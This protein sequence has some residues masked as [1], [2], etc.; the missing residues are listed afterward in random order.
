MGCDIHA[1]TEIKVNGKWLH[2][3][4]PRIQRD[5]RLFDKMAKVRHYTENNITP[6]S[7]PR[8]LPKGLSATTKLCAVHMGEDGHSH[9]WL[10]GKELAEVCRWW[11]ELKRQENESG[12]YSLEHQHIGYLFGNGWDLSEMDPSS[13]PEGVTDV[14]IVFW[15]DN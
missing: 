8:G 2:Y 1:H 15:F 9:S 10:S 12:F 14:R 5:Y 11:D 4:Q 13:Y 7:G 6:I 3:S